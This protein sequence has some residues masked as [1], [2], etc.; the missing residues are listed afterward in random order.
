MPPFTHLLEEERKNHKNTCTEG[1]TN[2]AFSH[3]LK[4]HVCLHYHAA[5][6][7]LTELLP[8][9]ELSKVLKRYRARAKTSREYAFTEEKDSEVI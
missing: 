9:H 3:V 6:L 1:Y 7:M 8:S 2:K 4:A 5:Q